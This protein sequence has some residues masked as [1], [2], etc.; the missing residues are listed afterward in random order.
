MTHCCQRTSSSTTWS[1][2]RSEY[3]GT[4]DQRSEA[5]VI[6][7]GLEIQR[8]RLRLGPLLHFLAA[9]LTFPMVH[10]TLPASHITL[11][12]SKGKHSRWKTTRTKDAIDSPLYG[13]TRQIG[14]YYSASRRWPPLA[15]ARYFKVVAHDLRVEPNF[16]HS[17]L[18][19]TPYLHPYYSHYRYDTNRFLLGFSVSSS[20]AHS[21]NPLVVC[22]PINSL[23]PAQGVFLSPRLY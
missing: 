6:R 18:V 23:T 10:P 2:C 19:I 9:P 21:G 1:P 7:S 15:H 12:F 11:T 17:Q 3:L 5:E 22:S 8:R 20:R 4:A 16:A 14:V 13:P